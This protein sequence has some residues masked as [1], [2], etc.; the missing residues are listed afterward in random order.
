VS[1]KLFFERR[2]KMTVQELIDKLAKMPK[3][4][5]VVNSSKLTQEHKIGS[6]GAYSVTG[7]IKHYNIGGDS[8]YYTLCMTPEDTT[9]ELVTI[10]SIF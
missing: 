5:I 2:N 1:K 3:D 6:V 9:E 4:A 10:V 7:Y 8:L